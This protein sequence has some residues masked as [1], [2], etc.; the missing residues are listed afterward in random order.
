M[1]VSPDK[2]VNESGLSIC[3]TGMLQKGSNQLSFFVVVPSTTFT[4]FTNVRLRKFDRTILANWPNR[5][6][7]Q[8]VLEIPL[9]SK[10][11]SREELKASARQKMLDQGGPDVNSIDTLL[12][13]PLLGDADL[14]TLE[15]D[16]MDH[17]KK[18][19]KR[20]PKEHS[21]VVK[22]PGKVW[23]FKRKNQSFVYS[24]IV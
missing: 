20:C 12:N 21:E 19:Y 5:F 18:H 17:A 6:K 3:A 23:V 2:D 10:K 9:A 14:E 15:R 4:S 24:D 8:W 7:D 22:I 16:G 1:T 13:Q 11:R